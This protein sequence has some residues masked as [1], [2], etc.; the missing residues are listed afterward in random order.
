MKI[1]IIII[2]IKKTIN[3]LPLVLAWLFKNFRNSLFMD[4]NILLCDY[5]WIARQ[6][7]VIVARADESFILFFYLLLV[8]LNG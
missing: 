4:I 1:I 8:T 6:S 5:Y 2:I 7:A 3:I